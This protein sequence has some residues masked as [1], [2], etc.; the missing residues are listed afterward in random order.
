MSWV[1]R[2]KGPPSPLPVGKTGVLWLAFA[3]VLPL[4][5]CR[6]L[7]SLQYACAAAIAGVFAFL[8]MAVVTVLTEVCDRWRCVPT[9]P[10]PPN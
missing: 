2:R 5:L 7:A 1:P 4:A 9:R 3:L 6:R 8:F 10:P